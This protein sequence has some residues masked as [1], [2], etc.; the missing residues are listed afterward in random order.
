MSETR[1]RAGQ[2]FSPLQPTGPSTR[3]AAIQVWDLPLRVV[4]W[5]IAVA[6]V[7][8]WLSAR[9][10]ITVHLWAGYVA[11]MLT[12]FRLLW[13]FFGSRYA[14]F[15]DLLHSPRRVLRHMRDVGHFRAPR[16]LG[17]DP[18]GGA[19]ALLIL[20]LLVVISVTGYAWPDSS[21]R[22][23]GWIRD[24]H[25]WS[26][27]LL[28]GLIPFHILAVMIKGWMHR[29]SLTWAMVTGWKR[30]EPDDDLPEQVRNPEMRLADRLTAI[31]ALTLWGLLGMLASWLWWQSFVL[32]RQH[33]AEVRAPGPPAAQA[34]AVASSVATP[35][36]PS[37][38]ATPQSAP[39]ATPTPSS[40]AERAL[41]L[42][43]LKEAREQMLRDVASE[44]ERSQRELATRL[45]AAK[46][47]AAREIA[48]RVKEAREQAAQEFAR[49]AAARA[50]EQQPARSASAPDDATLRRLRDFF[51]G[52]GNGTSRSAVL[53]SGGRLYDNWPA[54]LGK[55][56][57]SGRHPAWPAGA[58]A[59]SAADTWRCS[60]CHGWDYRGE[61]QPTSGAAG[62]SRSVR[63]AERL[64]P[65]RIVA[66]LG[67]RRHRF[68]DDVLPPAA[69]I[70]LAL[71]LSR[72]QYTAERY[73][74]PES[75]RAKGVASRGKEMYL[76]ACAACHGLDGRGIGGAT[77]VTLSTRAL[78]NPAEVFHK[79]RNGHPGAN[80]AALRPYLLSTQVDVLTYIQSL[81]PR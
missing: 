81:P 30:V 6:V 62:G 20:L 66:V 78:A 15:S 57:P 8:A 43:D 28:L 25:K 16:Y 5:G 32:P 35:A 24:V 34:Q 67:D 33:V 19:L 55:A 74:D 69:K 47:E 18:S 51:A 60:S 73:F 26:S 50:A 54:V 48:A 12:A 76:Q 22:E 9:Y 23:L 64:D 70:R 77:A 71:F 42:A 63:R 17:H 7:V 41:A 56:P 29:E 44:R 1:P 38:A 79:V 58:A 14:R 52:T 13:G 80:M 2:E 37:V 72:G 59:A 75:G 39:A 40:A 68:T 10:D 3:P 46:E 11:A 21:E 53:S 36:A 45:Q 61:A 65:E 49:L 4:H 27:N 31:E